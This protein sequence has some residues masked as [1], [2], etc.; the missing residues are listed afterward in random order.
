MSPA[1]RALKK[2]LI[3]KIVAYEYLKKPRKIW[4][5]DNI[6]YFWSYSH[7]KAYKTI[8]FKNNL[9][10]TARYKQTYFIGQKGF[11]VC[12]NFF[13]S[14]SKIHCS[15]ISSCFQN[16]LRCMRIESYS[17]QLKV[18]N[19]HHEIRSYIIPLK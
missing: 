11:S 8:I 15:V 14:F 6:A 3:H 5:H 19:F 13:F 10:V 18:T 16:Y 7:Y 17:L 9:K 1:D 4:F 2:I 12:L